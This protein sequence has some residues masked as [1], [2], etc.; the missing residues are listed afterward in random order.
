MAESDSIPINMDQLP[1]KFNMTLAGEDFTFRCYRNPYNDCLYMDCWDA[2]DVKVL[3]GEKLEYNEPLFGTVND[4]RLPIIYMVPYS[5]AGDESVVD[6]S[7]FQK[8]VFLFLPEE[9]SDS[10]GDDA[11]EFTD[12]LDALDDDD[13]DDDLD[14]DEEF[15]DD[16]MNLYGTDETVDDGV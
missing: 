5:E 12:D 11:S 10:N 13:E 9:D 15:E 4:P 3:K 2:D 8:S 7:N 16:D 14:N 1:E 6:A